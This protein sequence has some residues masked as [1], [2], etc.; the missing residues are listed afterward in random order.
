MYNDPELSGKYLGTITQDFV[1]VAD[2]LKDASYQIRKR[3]LSLYPIFVVS[4]VP[5]SLG[6]L[7]I[8][9][10]TLGLDWNYYASYLGEFSERQLVA[11][12][13]IEAFITAYKDPEEYCCLFV[14]DEQFTNFI[15]IPYPED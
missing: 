9:R 3:N 8:D 11:T 15:F 12:D 14:V 13:K 10:Q 4:K 5:V 1:K 7:L 6:V 2:T